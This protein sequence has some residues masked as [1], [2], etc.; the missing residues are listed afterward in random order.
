MPQL[1]RQATADLGGRYWPGYTFHR[2]HQHAL[3][4]EK[5]N[6]INDIFDNLDDWRHLP[7]YQLERRADVFFSLYLP[8]LLEARY[9][10]E[11][12]GLVPEFPLRIGTITPRADTNRSVKV[13]YLAKA[14]GHKT[15]VLVE[16]KTDDRSRRSKQDWYLERAE[17]VGLAAL[18]RGL[19]Q[20]VGATAHKGK[21]RYLLQRLEDLGLVVLESD[22]ETLVV[23]AP[24]DVRVV[25]LQPNE[26]DEGKDVIYFHEAAEIIE[27]HGD[28]LSRRFAVSL[29]EW[30]DVAAGEGTGR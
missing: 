10:F 22:G 11:I 16:L 28:G 5:M 4:A 13:D 1:P 3:Y 25:Y 15:V 26:G 21:Y 27:R 20:I 17:E 18:L 23:E 14:R 24:Y 6:R 8:E 12:E 9:G 2:L 30:A 19:E 29:R 7:A